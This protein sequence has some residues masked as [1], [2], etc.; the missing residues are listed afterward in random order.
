M[1]FKILLYLIATSILP[2]IIYDIWYLKFVSLESNIVLWLES[3][4]W[5]Y[6]DNVLMFIVIYLL[7]NVLGFYVLLNTLFREK[8][9][10]Q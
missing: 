2:F 3:R 9:V 6:L 10:N 1:K 4:T 5:L 8:L 7:V